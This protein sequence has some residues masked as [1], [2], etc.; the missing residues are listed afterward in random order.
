MSLESYPKF[1]KIHRWNRDIIITEKIDGTNGLIYVDS[2]PDIPVRAGSR[3]RWLSPAADNFG[4]A[5]WV[6]HNSEELARILGPG[7]HYGEW[8]G[9][10]IQRGY[11]L[12]KGERR[13]SLFNVHSHKDKDFSAVHGLGLVPL[14]Y[15][16]P[17]TTDRIYRALDLLRD[18][19]SYAVPFMNPEGIVIYHTASGVSYKITLANDDQP[20]TLAKAA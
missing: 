12:T 15:Q 11:G 4:F 10:G 16:G 8:W 14:V 3:N 13:F 17:N 2:N 6:E 9:S 5:Y 19:G 7:H 20:K 18:N 1:Q